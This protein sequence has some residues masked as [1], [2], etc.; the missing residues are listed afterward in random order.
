MEVEKLSFLKKL[1]FWRKK[2]E[3]TKEEKEEPKEE[4]TPLEELCADDPEAYEALYDTMFLDPKKVGTSMEEV[5]KSAKKLEESKDN[6]RASTQWKIAGGLAIAK[7]DVA[8]VERFFGKCAKLDPSFNAK[9]LE[10][11]IAERAVAK[12][13]QYYKK[14]PSEETKKEKP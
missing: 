8:K 9:I 2:E 4:K 11:G 6:L 13:Q 12:A 14:Y 3:E 1:K 10:P 7:G 5:V